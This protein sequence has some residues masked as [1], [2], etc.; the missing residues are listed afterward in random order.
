MT[1]AGLWLHVAG[2][3]IGWGLLAL[4]ALPPTTE[5]VPD[6]A[7]ILAALLAGV[8][9]VCLLIRRLLV[10]LQEAFEA[11]RNYERRQM[12]KDTNRRAKVVRWRRFDDSDAA[13]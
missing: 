4:D 1:R 13:G 6:R 2:A 3:S 7:V 10:P 5:L 11:G 8:F 12:M 9:S